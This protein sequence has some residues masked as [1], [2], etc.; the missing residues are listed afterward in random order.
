LT[1]FIF[2]LVAVLISG[3]GARDQLTVASLTRNL[4]PRPG[5]LIAAIAVCCASAAF[6]GYA[7]TL[8]APLLAPPARLFLAALALGF[9][10]AE[11]LIL[12]PGRD[13]REATHSLGALTL[14]LLVQQLTDAARFLIFGVAL[15]ADARMPA[16]LGGGIGGVLLLVAAWAAPEAFTWQRLRWIRRGLGVLMLL[17]ALWLGLS[18]L[19][20]V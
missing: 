5:T 15:V 13:A 10:G 7:A 1:G 11:A 9:A 17:L 14:V 2:A 3:L 18:A 19:G 12:Q 4:G 6:A 8:I 16:T 20:R